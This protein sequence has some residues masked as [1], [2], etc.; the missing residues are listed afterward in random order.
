MKRT[1]SLI[2]CIVMMLVMTVSVS[3]KSYSRA[4]YSKTQEINRAPM[5]TY[6]SLELKITPTVSTNSENS[7]FPYLVTEMAAASVLTQTSSGSRP[8][9]I[10]FQFEVSYQYLIT[11]RNTYGTVVSTIGR[12][13]FET[14]STTTLGTYTYRNTVPTPPNPY[15]AFKPY[16]TYVDLF[17]NAT[18][19]SYY[20]GTFWDFVEIDKSLDTIIKDNNL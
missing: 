2:M 11:S 13:Y 19:G 15:S 12:A 3:A 14:M 17:Y 20:T 10:G 7:Q 5:G 18:S 6:F 1:V 9:K 8:S 4:T 16:E